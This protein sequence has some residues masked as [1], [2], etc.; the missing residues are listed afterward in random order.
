MNEN[1]QDWA[2]ERMEAD[3]NGRTIDYVTLKP[4][5]VGLRLVWSAVVFALGGRA[6]YSAITGEPFNDIFH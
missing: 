3:R 4:K 1:A 5:A 2:Y 6:I